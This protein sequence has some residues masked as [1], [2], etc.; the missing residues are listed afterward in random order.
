MTNPSQ[1]VAGDWDRQKATSA[2]NRARRPKADNL[3][4]ARSLVAVPPPSAG[5]GKDSGL[6]IL[7]EPWNTDTVRWEDVAHRAEGSYYL[8][9]VP[10]PLG[11]LGSN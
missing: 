3:L 9:L 8:L 2:H 7:H 6:S 1:H 4:T 11:H 10:K 5:T